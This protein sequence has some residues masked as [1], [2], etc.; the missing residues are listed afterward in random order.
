[1]LTFSAADGNEDL[2]VVGRKRFAGCGRGRRR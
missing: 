1:M 2:E